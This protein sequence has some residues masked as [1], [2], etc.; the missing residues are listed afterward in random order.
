MHQDDEVVFA[1]AR[2]VRH[3]GFVLGT[4]YQLPG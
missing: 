4:H 1:V 2:E 3:G